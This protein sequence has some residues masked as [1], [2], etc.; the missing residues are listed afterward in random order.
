MDT[1][2]LPLPP[3]LPLTSFPPRELLRAFSEPITAPPSFPPSSSLPFPPHRYVGVA[4]SLLR[5][6]L[7][8]FSEPITAA[9]TA[10]H[11]PGVDLHME[12]R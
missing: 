10:T 2:Y 12:E 6:L 5:E 7:R 11:S 4:L 3:F 8:A 1:P 9:R